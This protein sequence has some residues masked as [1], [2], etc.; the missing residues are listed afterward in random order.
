VAHPPKSAH[1]KSAHRH[2]VAHQDLDRPVGVVLPGALGLPVGFVASIAATMISWAFGAGRDPR[3]GLALLTITAIA[4]GAV[5]TVPGAIAAGA[6]CWAFYSGFIL[7]RAGTLTLSRGGGQTLA[8]IVLCA[9]V[10]SVVAG[11]MRWARAVAAD[12]AIS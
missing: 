2:S 5:T 12:S 7:D 1:P 10:A 8:T 4:V 11:L 9:V 6:L 3:V